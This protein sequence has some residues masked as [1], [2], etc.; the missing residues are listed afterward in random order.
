M[1]VQPLLKITELRKK[2]GWSKSELARRAGMN[3]ATIGV[4]E[5]GRLTPYDAQLKKLAQALGVPEDDRATLMQ[6]AEA[7]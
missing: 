3:Q 7:A 2:V 6:E 1:E 4:I 5:S